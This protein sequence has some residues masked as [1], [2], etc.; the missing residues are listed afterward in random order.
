MK[1]FIGATTP[2]ELHFPQNAAG[3]P[4]AVHGY[5]AKKENAAK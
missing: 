5:H 2:G 3:E 1:K 4:V